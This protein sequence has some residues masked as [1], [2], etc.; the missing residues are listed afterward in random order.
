MLIRLSNKFGDNQ[1]NKRSNNCKSHDIH[2]NVSL[3][4]GLDQSGFIEN[5]FHFFSE[6]RVA[7]GS[8][9]LFL[10]PGYSGPGQ[11]GHLIV[12]SITGLKYRISNI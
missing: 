9:P 5:K 12:K 1:T 7:I 2:M 6:E 4:N 8:G 10:S 3:K 11:S